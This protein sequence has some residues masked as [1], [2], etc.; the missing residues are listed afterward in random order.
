MEERAN[1]Q[2]TSSRVPIEPVVFDIRKPADLGLAKYFH[3]GKDRAADIDGRLRRRRRREK[4]N[5][6]TSESK[7]QDH[8]PI[9]AMESRD[10]LRLT[11]EQCGWCGLLPDA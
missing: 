2:S 8:N 1:P 7:S 3:F 10:A 4:Q 11:G 5:R 6:A 9:V